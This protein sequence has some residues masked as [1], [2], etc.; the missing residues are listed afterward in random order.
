MVF[1][2][3]RGNR[4]KESMER[5]QPAIIAGHIN[6]WGS[7][8][9]AEMHPHLQQAL[10]RYLVAVHCYARGGQRS[11]QTQLNS[12]YPVA[13]GL[14]K[15]LIPAS[16]GVDIDATTTDIQ[17]KDQYLAP[18]DDGIAGWL[19]GVYGRLLGTG[20]RNQNM[21]RFEREHRGAQVAV[22]HTARWVA[23]VP[24]PGQ[25][26][27]LGTGKNDLTD[28]TRAIAAP[29]IR[30]RRDELVNMWRRHGQDFLILGHFVNTG[31]SADSAQRALI[32]ADNADAQEKYPA[33][34]LSLHTLAT[35]PAVWDFTGITPTTRDLAEQRAGNL[36]PS[37]TRNA[38]HFNA[39]GYQWAAH[40]IV[41]WALDSQRIGGGRV[42][43]RPTGEMTS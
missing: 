7:S 3:L 25:L 6:L 18:S 1:A 42:P 34:F 43:F 17:G 37:I 19:A 28:A 9:P 31:T 11:S 41:Q 5:E 30:Q 38:G 22:A 27:I 12:G 15:Q 32:V 2:F 10:A 24:T 39:A 4:R 35:D 26:N 13:L 36:P 14:K 8:S 29:L 21:L 23:D 20:T 16:G 33:H 40:R